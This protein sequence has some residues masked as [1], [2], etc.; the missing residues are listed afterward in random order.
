MFGLEEGPNT[1][2][3]DLH[4]TGQLAEDHDSQE[5]PLLDLFTRKLQ[6]S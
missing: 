3:S 6:E 1:K 2:L 4:D 5:F